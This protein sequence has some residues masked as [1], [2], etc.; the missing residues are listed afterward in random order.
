MTKS[1]ASDSLRALA[2]QCALALTQAGF[3]LRT[4][5]VI[6]SLEPA[7]PVAWAKQL[8]SSKL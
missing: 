5:P 1:E 2:S 8:G 3:L 6:L 4:P 7:M